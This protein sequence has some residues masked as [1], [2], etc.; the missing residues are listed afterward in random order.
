MLEMFTIIIIKYFLPVDKIVLSNMVTYKK[1]G[2][3][4]VAWEVKQAYS[5]NH[6]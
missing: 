4:M 2:I 5:Q 1:I 6:T 3:K